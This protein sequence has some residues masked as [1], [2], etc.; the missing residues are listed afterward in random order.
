MQDDSKLIIQFTIHTS[1]KKDIMEQITKIFHNLSNFA[2]DSSALIFSLHRILIQNDPFCFELISVWPSLECFRE[3][4]LN[5]DVEKLLKELT[6]LIKSVTI[7]NQNNNNHNV[8][9]NSDNDKQLICEIYSFQHDENIEYI[10]LDLTKIFNG[11]G[12]VKICQTDVGYI[13]HPKAFSNCF[14]LYQ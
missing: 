2:S 6:T 12:C 4:C 10:Q 7:N 3:W 9:K 11:F 5:Q 8:N 13:I 14:D 1:G